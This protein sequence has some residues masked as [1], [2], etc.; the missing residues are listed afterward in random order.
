[1]AITR[2]STQGLTR[3]GTAI[4]DVPDIPSI[5]AISDPGTDG[6]ATVA[7]TAAATGG[8]ASS[9][10]ATSTPGSITGSSSTSPITVTGLTLGT[11]YTFKVKGSNSTATGAESSASSSFTPIAHWAPAGAYDSI[12]TTTVGGGGASSIIFSSIPATYTHLQVR[13]IARNSSISGV[14]NYNLQF[15]NDTEG[16]YAVHDLYGDGATAA[17]QAGSSRG[18]IWTAFLPGSSATANAFATGVIDILDYTNTSKYKTL[19]HL[20]G[21][22][23]NGSGEVRLTSGL[24]QSTSAITSINIGLSSP[25]YVQYS[26]FA[27]YGIKGGN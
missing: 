25:T 19:R 20:Q 21:F 22:D 6:Y 9:Y 5:G 14:N 13:W 10:I 23:L 15:N 12:A 18:N 11:S 24:W 3:S 27:L 7:F 1:M 4:A 17:A 2:V 8:S 16:N 26:S